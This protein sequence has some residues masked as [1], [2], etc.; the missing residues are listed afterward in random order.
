MLSPSTPSLSYVLDPAGNVLPILPDCAHEGVIADVHLAGTETPGNEIP[1]TSEENQEVV[2]DVVEGSERSL[3]SAPTVEQGELQGGAQPLVVPPTLDEELKDTLDW[4]NAY[5]ICPK[6]QQPWEDIKAANVDQKKSWPCG[7]QVNAG[8]LLFEQKLAVPSSFQ[9][10][11]IKQHHIFLGHP[12]F[13]RLW[14]H[15]SRKFVW[16]NDSVAKTF[17]KSVSQQCETCQA[18]QPPL[19]LKTRIKP[20]PIPPHIMTHVAIDLFRM[21]PTEWEGQKFDTLI[22]CVDRHSGWMVA[23]PTKNQG[24]TGS[25]VAKLMLQHFWRPFGIPSVV[26]SDLGSHF[27]GSWWQTLCAH[28]GIRV[29]YGHAYHHQSNGRAERAGLQIIDRLKKLKTDHGH[30]SL[31]WVEVLPQLVDRL[32]DTPGESGY[33]PYEILFGRERHLASVPYEPPRENEDASQFVARQEKIEIEV[34]TSSMKH[35]A[36]KPNGSTRIDV[37]PPFFHVTKKV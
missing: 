19:T 17:T 37:F 4:E 23:V 11:V 16:A 10:E 1:T 15:M 34:A 7:F 5:K 25:K 28:L 20:T 26:T 30:K 22:V 32:H 27:V 36:R 31:S 29:A 14:G 33:S 8:K 21:P 13:E 35:T 12:G 3:N 2:V 9:Q 18:C 6:W 24:L